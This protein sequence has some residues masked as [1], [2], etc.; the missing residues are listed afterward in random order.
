MTKNREDVI[1]EQEGPPLHSTIK[2]FIQLTAPV[3]I[4]LAHRSSPSYL[5]IAHHH[6]VFMTAKVSMP[7]S[8]VS[9]STFD[10]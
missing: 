10:V 9:N 2:Y 3:V 8:L 5:V 4:I 7:S 1:E 6:F